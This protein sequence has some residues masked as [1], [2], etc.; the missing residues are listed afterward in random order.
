MNMLGSILSAGAARQGGLLAPIGEGAD[1]AATG[2]GE[3]FAAVIAAASAPAG[4]PGAESGATVAAPT[5]PVSPSGDPDPALVTELTQVVLGN[6]GV[7]R[8]E[9]QSLPTPEPLPEKRV[10]AQAPEGEALTPPVGKDGKGAAKAPRQMLTPMGFD[11][12]VL[13]KAVGG[14]SAQPAIAGAV[15]PAVLQPGDGTEATMPAAAK[16]TRRTAK[17]AEADAEAS[18]AAQPAPTTTAAVVLAVPTAAVPPAQPQAVATP[19]QPHA[20]A[21]PA[22][23]VAAQRKSIGAYRA[24]MSATP[25]KAQDG[26]RAG[27]PTPVARQEAAPFA[28][29]AVKPETAR[30]P[31]DAGPAKAAPPAELIARTVAETLRPTGNVAAAPAAMKPQ[32]AAPSHPGAVAKGEGEA[33]VVT[34]SVT[35]AV[36]PMPFATPSPLRAA[37]P[38]E[39]T[40]GTAPQ[41]SQPEKPVATVATAPGAHETGTTDVSRAEAGE[42]ATLPVAATATSAAAPA[43]VPT[44]QVPA[45]DGVA[46][47]EA[48]APAAPQIGAVLSDQV[49]DMGIEGQ[50]IDRLAREITQVADGTGHARFQLSPPHLGRIQVDLWQ[51]E[52]GGRVHLLTETDEA[53]MRLREG[54]STLQADARLAALSLGQV[55]IERAG[56]GNLDGQGQ[57][58]QNAQSNPQPQSQPRGQDSGQT[59]QQNGQQQGQP[60]PWGQNAT[61][62]GPSQGQSGNSGGQ[63]GKSGDPRAV[64][65]ERGQDAGTT[66]GGESR[67]RYA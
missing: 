13:T 6:G 24:G 22:L 39:A 1:G 57:R 38:A 46:R 45:V 35:E 37:R 28:E 55:V 54:Q 20:A 53:A 12:P 49:I 34:A 64:L 21:S 51:G 23:A 5:A 33:A 11:Q 29:V 2:L 63:H 19:A 44:V 61:G 10:L 65:E 42:V 47:T 25:T 43:P 27:Q 31:V 41:Q 16:P 17:T 14:A 18:S 52:A 4:E 36:T 7:A 8:G 40:A 67:V 66:T 62:S 15:D 48:S 9:A 59:A 3:M 60:Q 30:L 56:G 26:A 32:A 58:D 50:W